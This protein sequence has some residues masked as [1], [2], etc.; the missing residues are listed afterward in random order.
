[1]KLHV[2]QELPVHLS[3]KTQDAV[4]MN[5]SSPVVFRPSESDIYHG[6][7]HVE[8]TLEPQ[9]LETTGKYLLDDVSVAAFPYSTFGLNFERIQYLTDKTVLLKDTDFATWT[10][11]T[12]AKAIVASEVYGTYA[13]Q[14]LEYDYFLHWRSDARIVYNAGTTMKATVVREL[15]DI[16]QALIRRPNNVA[17]LE[18]ENYNAN[19]CATYFTAPLMVYYSTGGTLS[20]TWSASY[21]FYPS[22]TAATFSSSTS[23]SPTVTIKTP[24]L[25]ARC[26]SSYLSVARA[27]DV[28][29]QK[30]SIRLTGEL[31]RVQ[32]HSSPAY[33]MF[34][35][36]VSAYNG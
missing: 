26:N 7:Y 3:A 12:T 10:P 18:S 24:A 13:S 6:V 34:A 5:V 4:H 25:N 1:M 9:T 30:S 23:A 35:E 15:V 36:V 33:N 17:N 21:G 22:A 32:G 8:P 28:D 16:W 31:Y 19:V 20:V 27:A 29:M 14:M 2:H 11:S